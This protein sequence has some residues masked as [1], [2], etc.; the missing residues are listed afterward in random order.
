[1]FNEIVIAP[2][3]LKVK[4]RILEWL[5]IEVKLVKNNPSLLEDLPLYCKNGVF[6]CDLAN[7]LSG[8]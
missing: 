7:R 3:E 1:M 6:L 4:H 2:V 8:R 5:S